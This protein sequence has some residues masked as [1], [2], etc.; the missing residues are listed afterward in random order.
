MFKGKYIAEEMME[1]E[2]YLLNFC[3]VKKPTMPKFDLS[4]YTD[5]EYMSAIFE[6]ENVF[7]KIDDGYLVVMHLK[8]D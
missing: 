7:N 3:E 6:C 8:G 4:A 2:K 1:Y 5:N